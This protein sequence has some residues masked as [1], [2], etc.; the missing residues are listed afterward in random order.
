MY[1]SLTEKFIDKA[2]IENLFAL[3]LASVIQ[4]AAG[5]TGCAVDWVEAPEAYDMRL[6]MFLKEMQRED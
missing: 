2:G 3:D 6:E 4:N 5:V 1:S